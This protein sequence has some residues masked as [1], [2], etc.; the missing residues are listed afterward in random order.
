MTFAPAPVSCVVPARMG[1]TRFPGKPLVPILGV[2]MVVRTLRRAREA[3]CFDRVVCATDS[4]AVA[5]AAAEDGFETILTPEG[6]RTGSDRVAW[7]AKELGLELVVDL[8]GDEPLADP[9]LLRALAD[10]LRSDPSCWWSAA[11][12]LDPADWARDSVVKVAVD[13]DGRAV[14][15][16]RNEND[17]RNSLNPWF[18]HVGFYAYAAGIL[19]LFARSPSSPLEESR[20]LE[21]LR[22]FP[23]VA[24][25]MVFAARPT[26]SVDLPEDV[27]AVES[28]V[29][30]EH[31]RR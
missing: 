17:C 13:A 22:C 16:I 12:P 20:R 8:Q 7:A 31:E 25:R 3:G 19:D 18:R 14:D 10:G 23:Q 30:S 15:F 29:L 5:R 1:S 21:Q 6:M 27:A 9:G 11:C 4:E 28:L 26:A 2:P 24:V